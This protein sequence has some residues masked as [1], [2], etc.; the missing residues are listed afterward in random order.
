MDVGR[1]VG[2]EISDATAALISSRGGELWVWS[3]VNGKP[4][5]TTWPAVS[6]RGEW[7]TY[8]PYGL[9]VHVDGAIVSPD[10][11]I[12]ATIDGNRLVPHWVGRDPDLFG[13]LPLEVGSAIRR[14]EE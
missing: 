7:T 11:W 2:F 3:G 8:A 10:R 12:V 13:R 1:A 6:P 14:G 5:A 9:V 4:I